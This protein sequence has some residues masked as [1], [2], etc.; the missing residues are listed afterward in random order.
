[1]DEHKTSAGVQ[2]YRWLVAVGISVIA[3]L[4]MK[5]LERIEKAADGVSTLQTMIGT[6]NARVDGHGERL[7]GHDRK[8]ERLE[9]RVLRSPN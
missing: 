9:D 8:I 6:I 1:M 2:A 5:Q 4:S 7:T 3:A